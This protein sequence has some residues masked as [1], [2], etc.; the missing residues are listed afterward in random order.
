ML[1]IIIP[2]YNEKDNLSDLVKR[3]IRPL[4]LKRLEYELV[5]VDDNSTDGTYEYLQELQGILPIQLLRKQG[6]RGKAQ[7]LLQGFAAAKGDILAMI[8]ADLQYPPESIP[9]MVRAL[10]KNDIVV[11]KRTYASKK[12]RLRKFASKAFAYIFGKKVLGLN[13]DVQSGLKVFKRDVLHAIKLNPS[14]WGFDYEFLFKAQRLG[15]KIGQVP[16][17]F[18]TRTKGTSNINLFSNAFEMAWGAVKLRAK[19]SILSLLKF[20]DYPHHTERKPLSYENTE[21]FLYLPEIHSAK[22][23]VYAENISLVAIVLIGAVG[24]VAGLSLATGWSVPVILSG[25]VVALYL[26]LMLF[27]IRMIYHSFQ[28]KFIDV[29]QSELDA[30]NPNELPVY[31]ILIPLLNEPEVIPQIKKAMCSID[32][33]EEKLDIIITL[34]EYDHATYNAIQRAHLP[35]HFKTLILPDVKPKSKPKALN[36]A[37]PKARG[38]FLVI[39]DAEIV[40][41]PD[42]LKKAYLAF[43]KMPEISV[44][45]TRLDHYNP[46][47]SVITRLFNEEFSFHFDMMLPGLKKMGYPVPLAGH[48]VHFRKDALKEI[49]AWDPY[50]MTED[51]DLGIRLARFGHRIE[52]LNSFSLEEATTSMNAWI[53]QRTRWIKGF[54]QTTVVHMRHPLRFKNEL[55]LGWGGLLAFIIT[56]PASVVINIMNLFFWGL[57]IAWYATHSQLVNSLFPGPIYYTSLFTFV[58]GNFLFI[59]L[60]MVSSYRRERFNIVKYG[61]LS[62]LYWLLLAYASVRAAVE[63]VVN[64]YYWGKTTH[65]VHLKKTEEE[66]V[67]MKQYVLPG[68][69]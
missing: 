58:V 21:D 30:I 31:T 2:T 1:S 15:W 66:P 7:S 4:N 18:S 39:Y 63:F 65:G 13:V 56:V 42:Q 55:G 22:K 67:I 12:M 64:P 25:S 37:F 61:L 48:S 51:A 5:F 62:P 20:L 9:L 35:P 32:Y 24:A 60:N 36:V 44:F 33:P 49:G 23:H 16:I 40:P 68:N 45:Q 38:E 41:E 46:E 57:L 26:V 3:L 19:Y 17:K 50:N 52:I 59:Y 10:S 27:K 53:K 14:K 8:D 29:S 6:E 11:G 54:I 34:E 47:Q 28:Q 69:S 43:K